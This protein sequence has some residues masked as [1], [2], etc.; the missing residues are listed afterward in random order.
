MFEFDKGVNSEL[1]THQFC[2]DWEFAHVKWRLLQAELL[3][4]LQSF[5]RNTVE[6]NCYVASY[7]V[8]L[9]N[10]HSRIINWQNVEPNIYHVNH[11]GSP[12]YYFEKFE[13]TNLAK[14][15]Y[16]RPLENSSFECILSKFIL[17]HV[18]FHYY[19]EFQ[20]KIALIWTTLNWDLG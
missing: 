10:W 20:N 15:M 5:L 9:L 2:S 7:A 3:R 13:S 16:M 19:I 11:F 4:G 6:K 14:R 1:F 8:V 18:H 12:F 17:N